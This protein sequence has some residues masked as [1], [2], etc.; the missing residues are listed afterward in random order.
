MI[1]KTHAHTLATTMISLGAIVFSL[2]L[3]ASSVAYKDDS[4]YVAGTG[5]PNIQETMYWKDAENILQDLSKF[6]YLYV[7]FHHCAWTWMQMEDDGNDV[8]ENDYWYMGKIPPMGANVAFSLYGSLKGKKFNGCAADTF[9]NSFYTDQ[10]FN[11]FVDSMYHAGASGFSSLYS[12]GLT[13]DCQGGSGVGCDYKAGF[14]MHT[15]SGKECD[16]KNA[17]VITDSLYNLNKA[18]NTG[19]KC[20]NIYDASK[21]SGYSEGTAL[22]LLSYSHSCF[23]QDMLSPDGECP[24]PY[25]KLSQYQTNFHNGI[26]ESKKKDPYQVYHYRSLYLEEIEKGKLMTTVGAALLAIALVVFVGSERFVWQKIMQLRNTIA[27]EDQMKD[28]ETGTYKGSAHPMD[29]NIEMA[30]AGVVS[31]KSDAFLGRTIE[32]EGNE[33]TQHITVTNDRVTDDESEGVYVGTETPSQSITTIDDALLA[34]DLAET[35]DNGIEPDPTFSEILASRPVQ[36]VAKNRDEDILVSTTI[37]K[38]PE[39]SKQIIL[40]GAATKEPS[41]R[42]L[43]SSSIKMPTADLV[44]TIPI[45]P[46]T[47]SPAHE[48]PDES[49]RVDTS[50]EMLTVPLD[51]TILDALPITSPTKDANGEIL[52][53]TFIQKTKVDPSHEFLTRHPIR[54]PMTNLDQTSLAEPPM[55]VPTKDPGEDILACPSREKPMEDPDSFILSCRSID[56]INE[57]FVEYKEPATATDTIADTAQI[58]DD[59]VVNEKGKAH[60][61][62]GSQS[63]IPSQ[64]IRETEVENDK[65]HSGCVIEKAGDR[66]ESNTFQ[67]NEFANNVTNASQVNDDVDD[68][69][70]KP[71]AFDQIEKPKQEELCKVCEC[72]PSEASDRILP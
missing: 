55:Q 26:Q 70:T 39:N 20:T 61:T 29:I 4:Y 67:E 25:G 45:S 14:A 52:A 12:A 2:S 68:M 63:L 7:Q 71:Q 66:L 1:C 22:E 59:A 49:M 65:Y 46:P 15:Y 27:I 51:Q 24:D 41:E 36:I 16:P 43:T 11:V 10:G 34:S 42:N 64:R 18:M 60:I 56:S 72:R 21:Y 32:F 30:E 3:V 38:Q 8:D 57:D 13:A 50:L 62:A 53:S 48:E 19:A 69:R 17:T 6:Q 33:K 58:Q 37:Q 47:Q 54:M 9:I 23:Y 28:D 5:N 40:A 35:F 44:Q 31:N